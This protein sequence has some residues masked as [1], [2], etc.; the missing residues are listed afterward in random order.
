MRFRIVNRD[1]LL[2]ILI[3]TLLLI[4]MIL[5]ALYGRGSLHGYGLHAGPAGATTC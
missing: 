2:L 5:T 1:T 3:G 4:A